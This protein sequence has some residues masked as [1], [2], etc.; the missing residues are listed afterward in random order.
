MP[1]ARLLKGALTVDDY[2]RLAD[3]GILG[4]DDRVELLNGQIVEMTPIGP[5]HAGT[6]DALTRLFSQLVGDAAIVRVQNP[7]TLDSGS[8]PRADLSLL[9]PRGDAYRR[10]HPRPA[11]IFLVVEV[12]DSSIDYD[13]EIKVP[14]YARAGIPE[15][16]LVD[17]GADRLETY[18]SPSADGYATTGIVARGESVSASHLPHVTLTVNDILG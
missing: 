18:R 5:D 4:E 9:R 11:D 15:V 13:R 2:H 17:M 3:A 6:V 14:L 16:W 8:E 7:I 10:A 12:S 1:A